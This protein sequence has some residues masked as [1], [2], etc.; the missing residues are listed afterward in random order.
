MKTKLI[1]I[2]AICVYAAA[3]IYSLSW[4]VDS[5]IN[6]QISTETDYISDQLDGFFYTKNQKF[7]DVIYS[8]RDVQSE[9]TNMPKKPTLETSNLFDND[10]L[11]NITND[12]YRRNYLENLE[13]WNERYGDV[14]EMYTLKFWNDENS[15]AK[16]GWCLGCIEYKGLQE[17]SYAKEIQEEILSGAK[18]YSNSEINLYQHQ[19]EYTIW[20]TR[21]FP[22]AV[23]YFEKSYYYRPLVKN[24]VESAFD[25]WTNDN[26]TS[27]YK[28]DFRNAIIDDFFSKMYTISAKC[29][30]FYF[31]DK[32]K[33]TGI[34]YFNETT[35]FNQPLDVTLA[36][37]S[38]E[39]KYEKTPLDGSYYW[40]GYHKVYN[41]FTRPQYYSFVKK[42]LAINSDKKSLRIK[43]AVWLTIILLAIIIPLIVME[44]KKQKLQSE[45]IYDKLKRLCN[46]SNFMKNYDKEKVDAANEIYQKLLQTSPD[47][48]EMMDEIQ[49]QAVE[50]LKISLIEPSLLNELQKKVNPQNF[51]K[52]YDAEKV[53]LANDLYA[54][55]SKDNLTYN[56]FI[57]IQ[58]LSKQL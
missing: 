23:G 15:K 56:E 1:I 53:S 9:K 57:E 37:S 3:M 17:H 43:W 55:L 29:R 4:G 22:Y 30:Y 12:L 41:A 11:N 42:H 44:K 19:F 16:N 25:F 24:A 27:S 5:Y 46:P 35:L 48:K 40:N 38:N 54:R 6:K 31:N 10:T 14:K 58:E 7:Y 32:L 51:M 34:R 26:N 13:E 8:N 47:N 49:K 21:I 50:R 33:P 2:I 52:N 36:Y 45:T 28:E 20:F 18:K 39:E